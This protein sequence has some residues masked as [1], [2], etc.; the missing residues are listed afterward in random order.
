MTAMDDV[1][2]IVNTALGRDDQPL[3]SRMLS[4]MT[5]EAA[6]LWLRG[7]EP[8]LGGHGPW[9][10]SPSMAAALSWTPWARSNKAD[11][12]KARKPQWRK[13]HS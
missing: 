7:S 4:L 11:S 6:L 1:E 10:F 8:F 2:V 9:T 3:V 12:P 13:S 5:P